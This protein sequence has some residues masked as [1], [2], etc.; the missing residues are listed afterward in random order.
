MQIQYP[1]GMQDILPSQTG[2]WQ[3]LEDICRSASARYGY[4]EIRTPILEKTELFVRGVGE[5]TDI[6]GKEMYSFRDQGDEALTLRPELTAGV[7]RAVLQHNLMELSGTQRLWYYGPLFRHERPQKGRYRQFYQYG[8]ELLG[9]PYPESD[10]EVIQLAYDILRGLGLSEFSLKINTLGNA[11]SRQAYRDTL[12]SFLTPLADKLSAESRNR[13]GKNP[14]RILDSKDPGDRELLAD[15]PRFGDVL[16]EE[17]RSYFAAVQDML[18][19]LDISFVV[20]DKLVRGLDYYSHTVFEFSTDKLGAQDALGGGG[21][22]DGLFE[23]LGSKK[24]I[25][26]VGFAAGVERLLLLLQEEHL[27]IGKEQGPD[28]YLVGLD[29][30][31]RA[32]VIKLARDLRLAGKSVLTDLQRRSLKAQ[33]KEADKAQ[34]LTVVIIGEAE[35]VA[36]IVRVRNMATGEQVEYSIDTAAVQLGQL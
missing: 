31:S 4:R 9:S 27:A 5:G 7:A 29:D 10:V 25:P 8:A 23:Q 35:R 21:R 24:K 1:K 34:A 2:M 16:D 32:I 11:A 33:M 15:V 14:L 12:V 19:A 36:G 18:T 17:S 30:E 26:G 6:V 22:Y 3:A 28:F 20:S 13:L